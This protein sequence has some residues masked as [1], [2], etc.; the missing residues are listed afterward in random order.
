MIHTE[1]QIPPE[2]LS[3]PETIIRLCDALSRCRVLTDWESQTLERAVMR[4]R[5]G[6]PG[7]WKPAEDGALQAAVAADLPR[8]LIAQRLNR[9]YASVRKRIQRLKAK[10]LISVECGV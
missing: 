4:Q 3:T 9:S 6:R 1:I 10:G 2:R 7:A 8:Q 5:C